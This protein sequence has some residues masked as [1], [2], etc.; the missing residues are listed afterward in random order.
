MWDYF[1]GARSNP[2]PPSNL[3]PVYP[4][5][6]RLLPFWNATSPYGL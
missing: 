2:L 6:V 4:T 5:L 3:Y 1:H